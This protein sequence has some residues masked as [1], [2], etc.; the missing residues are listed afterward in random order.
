MFIPLYDDNPLR[1]IGRQYVTLALIAFTTLV[2]VVFQSGIVLHADR[3]AALSFGLIPAVVT[4]YRVLP[5]GYEQIPEWATFV[6]YAF[7]HGDWLHLAGNMLFVWVFGDNV[8]DALGHVRYL[9]FYLICA[10]AAAGV[11]VLLLPQS[12]SPLIGASGAASGIV[13]A[14]LMLHPKVRLWVLVFYKIPIPITAAWALG[15]W[16]GMQ[17]LNAFAGGDDP[18]AWWAHVGG[19][20]AGAVLIVVMRRPGVRLFD[21]NLAR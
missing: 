15:A 10:A 11:H 21:R 14:Y 16:I 12:E 4:D 8:E 6:T 19:L 7:L 2:F 17:L 20:L 13:A 18:V 9:A 1:S 3:A 5:P